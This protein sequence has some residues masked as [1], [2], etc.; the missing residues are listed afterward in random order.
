[1]SSSRGV[2]LPLHYPGRIRARDAK[3]LRQELAEA[4]R[5]RRTSMQCPCRVC[6]RGLWTQY[7][8]RRV[9]KHVHEYAYH[10]WQ[11]SRI[12]VSQAL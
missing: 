10:D 1:M 12:H 7:S 6:N 11:R 2:H 9:A 5:A 8:L 3:L 4:R